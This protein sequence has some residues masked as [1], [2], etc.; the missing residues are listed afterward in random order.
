[1][2]GSSEYVHLIN[3]YLCINNFVQN[4]GF[5]AISCGDLDA[6]LHKMVPFE[7][8]DMYAVLDDK[9]VI[10]EHFEFDASQSTRKG[11]KG[12]QEEAHLTKRIDAAEIDNQ[13]HIDKVEHD[14]SFE[15]W[16]ENFER[17]FDSHY[18]KI[19][20]YKEHVL[21][22]TREEGKE[23]ITGFFV[24][25]Q[26]C[27]YVEIDGRIR[28]L[29]YVHTTQFANVFNNSPEL[30]FILFAYICGIPQLIY[31]DREGMRLVPN[32]VDLTSNSVSLSPLNKNT[33]E[34]YGGFRI[35]KSD[36]VD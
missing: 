7:R 10:L 9:I 4:N 33:I 15:N 32:M 18:S 36:V 34:M 22:E 31:L 30:D 26:Y 3:D 29:P 25:N 27:P 21:E 13:F 19:N 35:N 8:P 23:I 5:H 12:K 6:A 16:K 2:N 1:M 20:M 11:M 24:E 17:C 28:E 14:I